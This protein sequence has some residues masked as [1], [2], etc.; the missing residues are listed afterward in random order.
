M[1]LV[2]PAAERV[3]INYVGDHLIGV[4]AQLVDQFLREPP[5]GNALLQQGGECFGILASIWERSKGLTRRRQFAGWYTRS[6]GN[7]S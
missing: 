3:I 2:D 4:L 1:G 7:L 6:A 5:D